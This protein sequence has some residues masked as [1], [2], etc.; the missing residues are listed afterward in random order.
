MASFYAMADP[1]VH[2]DAQGITHFAPDRV[3]ERYELFFC[4]RARAQP[5]ALMQSGRGNM[6]APIRTV[7]PSE[8]SIAAD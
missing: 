5:F 6:V 7:R 8:T 1:W 2:L 4:G 3:G